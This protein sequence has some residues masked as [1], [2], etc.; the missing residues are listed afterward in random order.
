MREAK[1]VYVKY[2]DSIE[3]AGG[4]GTHPT[5]RVRE[6]LKEEADQIQNYGYE[7]LSSSSFQV[8]NNFSGMMFEVDMDKHS[9]TCRAWQIYGY[10]CRHACRVMLRFGG[11]DPYR[12]IEPFMTIQGYA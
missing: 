5:N 8:I 6:K 4:D 10:P 1:K 3:G 7:Q 2:Q 11:Q 9:C 12:C